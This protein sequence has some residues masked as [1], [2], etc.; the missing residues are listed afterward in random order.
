MLQ[1]HARVVDLQKLVGGA[2]DGDQPVVEDALAN[3][4]RIACAA[5]DL[6]DQDAHR[7]LTSTGTR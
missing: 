3:R 1:L 5:G 2:A 4:Q 6:P 7:R